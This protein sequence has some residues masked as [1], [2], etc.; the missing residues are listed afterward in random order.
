MW[1]QTST[2]ILYFSSEVYREF[3]SLNK[4]RVP[5][6]DG[7]P[8][9]LIELSAD[10][11]YNWSIPHKYYKWWSFSLLPYHEKKPIATF[12]YKKR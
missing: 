12:I 1:K 4:K 9:Q 10:V 11:W 2:S 6:P 7:I 5:G 8:F 3:R